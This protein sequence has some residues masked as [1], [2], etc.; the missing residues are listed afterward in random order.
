MR[1]CIN[2]WSRRNC[3][4]QQSLRG[5]NA[6]RWQACADRQNQSGG[7]SLS[8][9]TERLECTWLALRTT[10][11]SSS[12]L[13]HIFCTIHCR[14]LDCR[15]KNNVF[16]FRT[17][18]T[19]THSQQHRRPTMLSY[20]WSFAKH[21]AYSADGGVL[22]PLTQARSPADAAERALHGGRHSA[23]A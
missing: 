21:V 7:T 18:L 20:A 1:H 10:A 5:L 11:R 14:A 16:M 13:L 4:R 9:S 15:T 8:A 12:A 6:V 19:T 17:Y 3:R 23:L 2:P 22:V